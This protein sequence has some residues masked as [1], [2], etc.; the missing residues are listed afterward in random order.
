MI[1]QQTAKKTSGCRL[2]DVADAA[3]QEAL[4]TWALFVC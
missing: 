3:I 4:T 1:T 2:P